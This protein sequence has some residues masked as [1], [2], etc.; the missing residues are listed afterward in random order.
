MLDFK[1]QKS[2]LEAIK[3]KPVLWPALAECQRTACCPALWPQLPKPPWILPHASPSPATEWAVPRSLHMVMALPITS[4][5]GWCQG[6]WDSDSGESSVPWEKLAQ[7]RL[8]LGLMLRTC[9]RLSQK[10][11]PSS[12]FHLD[13]HQYCSLCPHTPS[14]SQLAFPHPFYMGIQKN[15]WP[16]CER[17]MCTGTGRARE[18]PTPWALSSALC[19]KRTLLEALAES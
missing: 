1:G 10:M 6:F 4:S 19:L 12:H 9:S 16:H 2:H 3:T 7:R 13:W 15:K 8:T 11:V 17:R 18:L 5:P 14:S